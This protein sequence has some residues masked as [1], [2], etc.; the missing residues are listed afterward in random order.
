[1]RRTQSL[2]FVVHEHHASHLHYD[3]R[4]E[5]GGALKSWAIPKG[6]S[7]NPHDT[8]LAIAVD[9]HPL[10]YGDFEGIIPAGRYGAG[11]VVIWDAGEFIPLDDPSVGLDEGRL[12]FRLEGKRLRG[13]FALV[14]FTGKR[15]EW[16]L[17]KKH[18]ADADTSWKIQRALTPSRRGF[19]P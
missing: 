5:I 15:K 10:E 7:M 13:E 3:F 12:V 14:R 17:V 11:E 16:L 9:D 19:L 4:L 2:Q 1:M 6:P 18:D 8:R